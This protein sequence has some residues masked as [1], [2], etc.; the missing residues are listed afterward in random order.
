MSVIA[1]AEELA[2][3]LSKADR[4]RLASKLIASLGNPFEDDDEDII[5]LS[6]SRA[7]EMYEHPE[8]VVSEEE[9]WASLEEY[10]RR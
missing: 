6:L 2:L 1:E 10:R 4:G 7:K 5:E 9:F 8:T 3:S